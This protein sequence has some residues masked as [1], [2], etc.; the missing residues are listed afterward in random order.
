MFATI[1]HDRLACHDEGTMQGCCI[2]PGS[3]PYCRTCRTPYGSALSNRSVKPLASAM[4]IEAP[5]LLWG[6]GTGVPS[7]LDMHP[8]L[9]YNGCMSTTDKDIKSLSIRFPAHILEQMKAIAKRHNRSLSGEVLTA[10]Q[11]HIKRSQK[12][13]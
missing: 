1:D 4:G 3:S 5:F 10:L 13:K 7:P 9:L 2:R 12:G 6:L 8:F 11:E